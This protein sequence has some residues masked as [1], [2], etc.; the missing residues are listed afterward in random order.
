[1][2]VA[3]TGATG[4]IGGAVARHLTALGHEVTACGKRPSDALVRRFARY[5][6]W[7]VCSGPTSLPGIDAIVHCAARVG[8]WGSYAD[9]HAVNVD[10]LQ[11]V[12]DS[13]PS[14]TRFVHISSAS[15]YAHGQGDRPLTE[16]AL[17]AEPLFTAYARSKVAAER[18][19]QACGRPVIILRPHAVYG[20]GDTTLLPRVLRARRLGVLPLPGDG[21]R[22]ISVTYVGNLVD[23]VA[24]ALASPTDRGVFNVADEMV[25]TVDELF[26]HLLPRLG[27]AARLVHVPPGIAHTLAVATEALWHVLRLTS[28]PR[29]TRYAVANLAEPCTIDT[30]R[31]R[32]ELGFTPRW[33]YRDAPM[34]EATS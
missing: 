34:F 30:S 3:V 14:G 31:I 7:D 22:K 16:D 24:V 28:E 2:R 15:V 19:L 25:P 32:R 33:N 5:H 23:A 4:F 8:Q 26:T 18:T 17:V 13:V 20:P 10:G 1:M 9:Y 12:L 11:A 6:Q 21:R 27:L 29:L